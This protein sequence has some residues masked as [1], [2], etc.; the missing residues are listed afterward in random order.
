MEARSGAGEPGGKPGT[1]DQLIASS[2]YAI[3]PP[4]PTATNRVPKRM[5]RKFGSPG[6]V[7]TL[8]LVPSVLVRIVP[9]SPTTTYWADA[10][11][12]GPVP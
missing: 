8:Q 5:A 3:A 11:A 4:C 10:P 12:A 1:D 9:E 7:V 2:L 6:S